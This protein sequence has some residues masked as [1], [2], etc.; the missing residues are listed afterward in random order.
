M[1]GNSAPSDHRREIVSI[2]R[3]L[4]RDAKKKLGKQDASL[5]APVREA[6]SAVLDTCG[7]TLN[8][9]ERA[10]SADAPHLRR[11]LGSD[12]HELL[13]LVGQLTVATHWQ[14]PAIRQVRTD[15]RGTLPG[16][17][18][19]HYNDYTRD[20]HVLGSAYESAYRRAFIRVP[21]L[22]PVYAFATTSGMAAIATAALFV[23]G[24]TKKGSVV[25][26]GASCYFETKQL[27]RGMFGD[28]VKELDLSDASLVR[29]TLADGVPAAIFADTI[30][31]EPSMRVVDVPA[32][33]SAVSSKAVSRV[34]VVV[35]GSTTAVPMHYV[36]GV[37]MPKHIV[38]IGAESQNKL[39]Q[40]GL[41]R[42]TAGMLWG[43]GY[44]SWKLYDYRDH[45]GT[46]A[47]DT[48]IASLPT[49]HKRMA[50]RYANLIQTNAQHLAHNLRTRVKRGIQVLA[51]DG[52]PYVIISTETNTRVS[53]ERIVSAVMK[54]AA[55]RGIAIVEGT[56]FG[57]QT[58][59]IY[60]V[61][62]NTLYEKPFLRLSPGIESARE[63]D[64]I[65]HLVSECL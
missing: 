25:W 11:K 37:R 45:A 27:V 17:I 7:H 22:S 24:E 9:Y 62:A 46:I 28:R 43:T 16:R 30:G 39:L 41:D 54:K 58:T 48:A 44:V 4:L 35:D 56:S 19:A 34:I 40:Y 36:H 33:L 55:S 1:N 53:M 15:N 63:I 10:S 60:T 52:S 18:I 13:G 61:A 51:P 50:Q 6:L 38:L 29:R 23:L 64:A 26:L 21:A 57:F 47:P 5:V 8:Q 42:V 3:F 14:S 65:A 32:L 49:P 31:N 59:R 2:A 20:Q 12:I